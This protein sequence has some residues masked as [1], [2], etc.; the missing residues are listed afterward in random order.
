MKN[1]NSLVKNLLVGA[2]ALAITGLA[3][4]VQAE[5]VTQVITVVKVE[6]AA[7]YSTDNR[8]WQ[9]LRKGDVLHQGAVI[10]TAEQSAVDLFAGDSAT[11]VGVGQISADRPG[12]ATG[13]IGGAGFAA[14]SDGPKPNFI[15]VFESSVVSV[16]KLVKER[17][18]VEEAAD[19]QLDLRSGRILGNVKKLSSASRYEV[20]IPFGVA[21]IRGT[22][23]TVSA[24]GVV[25]V[26]TGSVTI[27]YMYVPPGS[28]PGTAAVSNTVTVPAGSNFNPAYNNGVLTPGTVGNGIVPGGSETSTTAAALEAAYAKIIPP[29]T[30]GSNPTVNGVTLHIS[31]N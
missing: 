16:D 27:S 29:N 26:L 21:G 17:T 22:S 6:G 25:Y 18:G 31:P 24:A 1:N 8:T 3:V 23:Y 14:L 30:P 9:P 20:K 13:A 4:N 12:I 7:R 2:L 5:D 28:A 15:H 10:Q 19:T 11:L